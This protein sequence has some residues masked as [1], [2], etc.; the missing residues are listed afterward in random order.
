MLDALGRNAWIS[1]SKGKPHLTDAG[2]AV[3]REDVFVRG[4][5]R[6]GRR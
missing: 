2:R 3:L 6:G 1:I 4:V 5:H